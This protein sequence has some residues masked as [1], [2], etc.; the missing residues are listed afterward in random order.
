[1]LGYVRGT[2]DFLTCPDVWVLEA[3]AK[4]AEKSRH[5]APASKFRA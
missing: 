2:P 3:A 4:H 1:M 5:T